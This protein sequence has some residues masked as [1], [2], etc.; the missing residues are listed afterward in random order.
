MHGYACGGDKGMGHHNVCRKHK[1]YDYGVFL[2]GLGWYFY[3]RLGMGNNKAGRDATAW[4]M[5]WGTASFITTHG[6]ATQTADQLERWQ[7]ASP[8]ALRGPSFVALFL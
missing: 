6:K 1:M 4:Q 2:L 7:I 8:V 5:W 3:S